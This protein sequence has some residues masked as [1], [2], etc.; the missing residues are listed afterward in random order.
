[1]REKNK[2]AE[3]PIVRKTIAK[4]KPRFSRSGKKLV[5][6]IDEFCA[7]NNMTVTEMMRD[8]GFSDG[9][10]YMW[11]NGKNNARVESANRVKKFIKEFKNNAAS[12]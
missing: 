10:Y 9:A 2:P 7:S 6:V 12:K 4:I 5:E 11:K 8:M 1:L 3:K